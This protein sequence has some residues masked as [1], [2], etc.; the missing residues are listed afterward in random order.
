M[1]KSNSV[2]LNS[3]DTFWL[4]PQGAERGGNGGFGWNCDQSGVRS[5]PDQ[6]WQHH[7]PISLNLTS[8]S[9]PHRNLCPP[10]PH[11]ASNPPSHGTRLPLLWKPKPERRKR[12]ASDSG[13]R[14]TLKLQ[15]LSP[16]SKSHRNRASWDPRR[17]E[18]EKRQGERRQ[19]QTQTEEGRS[20]LGS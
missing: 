11:P 9:P 7:T 20:I 13:N 15:T 3:L 12:G 4:W 2:S 10:P 1:C 5:S 14:S 16:R 6:S 17:E 18:R 19:R 8:L